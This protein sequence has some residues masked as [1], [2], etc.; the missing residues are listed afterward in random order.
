MHLL[1]QGVHITDPSSP[2]HD[3]VK[4]ILI[5]DGVIEKIA[6]SVPVKKEYTLL[7]FPGSRISPGWFDM[8]ASFCDPG[9]EYKENLQSGSEA[10]LAG[11]FTSV[12]VMPQTMPALHSKAE[13]EYIVN[14]SAGLPVH[15]LPL[16]AVTRNC[17]GKDLTEMYDMRNAGAVAFTDAPEAFRD[18]GIL[19]RSLQYVKAFGGI[20]IDIPGDYSMIGHAHVNEGNVSTRLGMYG[21][22]EVLE[23]LQVIRAISLAEYTGSR[24]HIGIIS[25]AGVLPHIREAKKKKIAVSAGVSVAHLFFNEDAIGDYNTVFKVNPPLR[26]RA[27]QQALIDAVADGTI[28]V[29]CSYHQPHD[30]DAK[31]VE[32]EAAAFGME[33]LEA[34]F[35]AAWMALHPYMDID[36]MIEKIAVNPRR[37]LGIPLPS[38]EEGNKAECTIFEA[39]VER[40][41]SIG[42]IRSRSM[43]SG[44]PG[45]KLLGRPLAIVNKGSYKIHER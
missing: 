45:H 31:E 28:D 24:V 10:A 35:S 20:V 19:L 15:I 38:I 23:E 3:S 43:N 40:E 6:V 7:R 21:I 8:L 12:C 26:T 34:T 42:Q 30:S 39:E 27:D 16:G 4:D 14:A 25:S 44:F 18:S 13:I 32:F 37:I 41:F 5:R 11:G 2:F 9:F 33:T 17:E 29:I 36:K 22:P 1:I